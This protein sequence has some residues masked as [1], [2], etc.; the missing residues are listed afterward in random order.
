M[1]RQILLLGDPK[2]YEISE[3]VTRDEL[4]EL[5]PIFT[6]MFDCIKAFVVIMA[7]GGQLLPHKSGL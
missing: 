6:D 5:R 1:E 3:K 2:L 7:L 4:E